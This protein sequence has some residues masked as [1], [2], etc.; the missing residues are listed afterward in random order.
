VFYVFLWFSEELDTPQKARKTVYS[1]GFWR[2]L[3]VFDNP[4]KWETIVNSKGFDVFYG[5]WRS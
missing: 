3:L 4:P 5:F 2:F 1:K